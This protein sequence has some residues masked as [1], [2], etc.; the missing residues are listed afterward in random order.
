VRQEDG[1]SNTEIVDFGLTLGMRTACSA[2][3]LE[4]G[5]PWSVMNRPTSLAWARKRSMRWSSG[6]CLV[7]PRL[8]D[9]GA[10]GLSVSPSASI[11]A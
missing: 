2:I 8:P 7:L 6:L 3:V 10:R 11:T 1:R 5:T 4:K 9:G